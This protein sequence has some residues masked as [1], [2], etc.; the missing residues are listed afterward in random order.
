MKKILLSM[1]LCMPMMLA[2]QNGVTVSGL[3]VNAGTVT[4]NVSWD[5]DKMPVALWSDSV[6]VFVDY[7]KAGRMTRLPITAVTA[8]AGAATMTPGNDKGAWVIGNARSAGSFSA[9]VTLLTATADIAGACAYASN[10]P[11]VGEYY[12]NYT[13][14]AF[15]GTPPYE[16][17]L[18][19]AGGGTITQTVYSPYVLACGYTVESV[20]DKTGTVNCVPSVEGQA[21]HATCGCAPGLT[22]CFG[23]CYTACWMSCGI[24]EVSTM[25]TEGAMNISSAKNLCQNKGSD[26]R[27]PTHTELKCM[28][29]SK[30]SLPGGYVSDFYWSS[31]SPGSSYAIVRFSDCYSGSTNSYGSP[32]YLS[33]NVKCVK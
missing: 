33:L 3:S 5:R 30:E 11:P 20:T 16:V 21:A 27:V 6:W 2:A 10:Y 8:S 17:V 13:E 19:D 24:T 22:D 29:D 9:T 23:T 14:I 1:M 31:T 7:N 18:K 25:D 32:S 15:T 26:W 4:F 28:C 12:N